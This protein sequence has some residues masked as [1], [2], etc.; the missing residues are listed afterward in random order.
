E[1]SQPTEGRDEGA[2]LLEAL[3]HGPLALCGPARLEEAVEPLVA[4][5]DRAHR[6]RRPRVALVGPQIDGGSSREAA[7]NAA[8]FVRPDDDH[9]ALV[10]PDQ[11]SDPAPITRRLVSEPQARRQVRVPSRRGAVTALAPQHA[12]DQPREEH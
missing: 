8:L 7:A 4:G 12:E 10:G 2:R 3:Q 9:E 5:E 11:G 1:L 6:L